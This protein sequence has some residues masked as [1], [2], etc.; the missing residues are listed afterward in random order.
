MHTPRRSKLQL[1]TNRVHLFTHPIWTNKMTKNLPTE[2]INQ[3]KMLSGQPC[4]IKNNNIIIILMLVGLVRHSKIGYLQLPTNL[5][6]HHLYSSNMINSSLHS[7]ISYVIN[8]NLQRKIG[9]MTKNYKG[10]RLLGAGK[11]SRI[12][13]KLTKR[14]EHILIILMSINIALKNLL[15]TPAHSLEL[16]ICLWI[17]RRRLFMFIPKNG[18]QSRPQYRSKPEIMV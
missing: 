3:S 15:K 5:I 2:P 18:N 11:M 12:K 6:H 8:S 7:R 4:M 17:V 13:S 16:P 1:E 10:R 14:Q 9:F